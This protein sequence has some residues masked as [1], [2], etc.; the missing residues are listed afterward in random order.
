MWIEHREENGVP[1]DV[2]TLIDDAEDIKDTL[3]SVAEQLEGIDKEKRS[4]TVTIAISNG[5]IDTETDLRKRK[6]SFV[7]Y[8]AIPEIFGE[9]QRCGTTKCFATSI[10]E[11]FK[12][13]GFIVELEPEGVNYDI[14]I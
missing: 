12:K 6:I 14:S 10:A 5:D 3:L 8:L 11:Y 9:I 13:Y 7:D 4:Y 2:R 1:N